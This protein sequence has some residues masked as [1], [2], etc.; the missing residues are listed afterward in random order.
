M[1]ILLKKQIILNWEVRSYF[2]LK[3]GSVYLQNVFLEFR[4]SAQTLYKFVWKPFDESEMQ[5]NS[6][7]IA[8]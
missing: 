5:G 4:N 6:D 3:V 2:Y 7:A 8:F 1:G